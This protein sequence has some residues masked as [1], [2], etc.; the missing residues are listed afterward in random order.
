[1][2]GLVIL[3]LLKLIM[4][5]NQGD[6]IVRTRNKKI[7]FIAL[8]LASVAFVDLYFQSNGIYSTFITRVSDISGLDK[9]RLLEDAAIKEYNDTGLDGLIKD[10]EFITNITSV[11][12]QG[13]WSGLEI[14]NNTFERSVGKM[15]MRIFMN[16]SINNYIADL[17]TEQC[18]IF[19][20]DFN[21]GNYKD[22]WISLNFSIPLGKDFYKK[23]DEEG[24]TNVRLS[25]SNMTINYLI[26]ELFDN[27][28]TNGCNSTS[29]ELDFIPLQKT[30]SKGY[31]YSNTVLYSKLNGRIHD[32]S[33]KLNIDFDLEVNDDI[34]S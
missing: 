14:R 5:N 7:I 34:V 4:D 18:L 32:Q 27:S 9:F 3:K 6:S 10:Y 12:Y 23:L 19:Y 31:E 20:A 17:E 16:N 26:A 8:F 22:R 30:F 15:D 2:L 24:T 29:L 11:I 13:R 1:L 21:D 33:C 28:I 25:G